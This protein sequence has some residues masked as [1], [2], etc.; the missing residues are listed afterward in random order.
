MNEKSDLKYNKFKKFEVPIPHKEE[1][2]NEFK[3]FGECYAHRFRFGNGYGASVV[4]HFGSFGYD[5]DLFEL[6]VLKKDAL[7]YD[8]P[9]TNDVIGYLANNEVLELLDKIKALP[10]IGSNK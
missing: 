4:K 5:Y 1:F 2:E 6:A 9:I 10:W 8:T 3:Q 7:C